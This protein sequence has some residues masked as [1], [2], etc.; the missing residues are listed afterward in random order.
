MQRRRIVNLLKVVFFFSIGFLLIWLSLNDLS[1]QQKKEIIQSFRDANYWWVALAMMLG[2]I[3]HLTRSLRWRMLFEPLGYKPKISNTFFSVMLGYLFNLA[4]P[5]LGEVTRCGAMSRYEKVP[6]NKALGTVV[7]ER[8]FDL[9]TYALLICFA[10]LIEYQRISGFF[11]EHILDRMEEK[12]PGIQQ[13]LIVAALVGVMVLIVFVVFHRKLFRYKLFQKFIKII[14][15]F[16]DGIRSIFRL[17][18][19]IRFILLTLVLWSCYYLMAYLCFFSFNETMGLSPASGLSVLT[20]GTIAMMV[21]PG[22]IGLYPIIVQG[23]LTLYTISESI[24]YAMGWVIW[25]SQNITIV[26][27]GVLSWFL[28]YF[29]NEY[30]ININ[31]PQDEQTGNSQEK[32]H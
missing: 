14:K 32:N 7:T 20:L 31:K 11:R 6:F 12:L 2:I 10:L 23:V 27:V 29:F 22:G 5:R 18:K 21:T 1:D 28:L 30:K 4:V 19:W 17:K 16:W 8:A 3:S 25:T 26:V 24:G 15:G 9:F 13:V